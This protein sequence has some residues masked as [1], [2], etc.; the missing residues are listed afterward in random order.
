MLS[1]HIMWI[2]WIGEHRIIQSSSLS[3][4]AFGTI[5]P[6]AHEVDRET[7]GHASTH[8]HLVHTYTCVCLNRSIELCLYWGGRGGV[9]L[10]ESAAITIASFV[11]VLKLIEVEL[12]S[13]NWLISISTE[14]TK[15]MQYKHSGTQC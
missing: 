8:A 9:S 11:F 14:Y 1:V 12:E 15:D 5:P 4:S 3:H 13:Q 2:T 6:R 7:K 10:L